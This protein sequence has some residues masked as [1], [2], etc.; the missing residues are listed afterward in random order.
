MKTLEELKNENE[1]LQKEI[2]ELKTKLSKYTNPERNKKYYEK[3]KDTIIENSKKARKKIPKE[4]IKE[5]NRR[6]YLK[7]KEKNI[8]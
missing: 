4:K 3:N 2:D 8:L 7:R 5:Y 6:A 1:K